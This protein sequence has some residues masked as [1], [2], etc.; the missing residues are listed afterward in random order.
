VEA[1]TA[2][3]DTV[4]AGMEGVVE[5]TADTW[6]ACVEVAVVA[7]GTDPVD[8]VVPIKVP[9]A[10]GAVMAAIGDGTAGVILGRG[11]VL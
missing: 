10:V 5:V 1:D 6:G 2:E 8:T 11:T 4:E 9:G 7:V 3:A